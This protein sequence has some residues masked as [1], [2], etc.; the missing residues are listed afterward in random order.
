MQIIHTLSP[1]LIIILLGYSAIKF[2]LL[3]QMAAD[4]LVKLIFYIVLPVT[5]FISVATLPIESLLNWP[6]MKAYFM[7]VVVI[8][9]IGLLLSYVFFSRQRS[10]LVINTMA[11]SQIN[12]AYIALP[13]FLLRFNNITPVISSILANFIFCIIIIA[14]FECFNSLKQRNNLWTL[15][16]TIFIK[17]PLL[18]GIVAG[19]IC[20]LLH[21]T[22]PTI[23][24]STSMLIKDSAAFLALFALGASLAT[25]TLNTPQSQTETGLLVLLKSI[26]HPLVAFML[27]KYIFAL[28]SQ[29]LLFLVL[30]AA[31]PAAKNLFIF[32]NQYQVGKNRSSLVV[33]ITTLLSCVTINLVLIWLQ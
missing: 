4:I 27:G 28:P 9:F 12:S 16:F 13:L 17:A 31:M 22:L 11:A 14:C 7:S 2:K 33:L 3:P 19:F 10:E 6:F 8:G 20:S 25:L 23:I 30:L 5:L 1:L 24:T 15:P 32:A 26:G 21:L 29:G 18:L